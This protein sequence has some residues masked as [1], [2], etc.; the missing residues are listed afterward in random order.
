MGSGSRTAR[1]QV[2]QPAALDLGG[3]PQASLPGGAHLAP[4]RGAAARALQRGGDEVPEERR[5][6]LGARLELGVELRGDE[7]GWSRS[8]M[9]STR[10]SSGEVPETTS[11]AA[12]RRLRSEMGTW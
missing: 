1:R 4:L 7:D 10:R 2:V 5:R 12:S 6:A 9:T 8:S 3:R 11:P